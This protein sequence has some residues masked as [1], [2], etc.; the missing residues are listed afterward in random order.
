MVGLVNRLTSQVG[1]KKMAIAIL[2]KR[3][4]VDAKGKL[5]AAGRKRQSLGAA[6]RAKDR[7]A[8][9][10]GGKASQYK[11]NPRTNRATKK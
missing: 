9:T 11:Y 7:A 4:H 10:S 1:S 8:K 2:K 6:G 3:G 5:T